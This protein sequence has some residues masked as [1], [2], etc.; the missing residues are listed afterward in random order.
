MA[1]ADEP[2]T[3][4]RRRK[5]KTV[6]DA[7]TGDSSAAAPP[8][9]TP[10]RRPLRDDAPVELAV[11]NIQQMFNGGG[12]VD[13][14]PNET[15]RPTSSASQASASASNAVSSS[16]SSSPDMSNNNRNNDS[17][18]Q[19]LQD[20]RDMQALE[21]ADSTTDLSN[22]N[23]DQGLSL[24][25]ML[26]TIVTVDFFVVC[27]FLLWFLAGIFCSYILKDDGV[28]IAFNSNFQA[29]VQPALGILM[30][31]SIAGSVLGNDDE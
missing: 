3:S 2:E 19:L 1:P 8:A 15:S 20:A 12:A 28:Q 11:P 27:G 5:R 25:S 22:N 21:Q 26:S 6:P 13:D 30:I 7:T 29:F 4:S 24:R 18:Q 14:R 17:L 9:P 16:F 23:D 10:L 31:G